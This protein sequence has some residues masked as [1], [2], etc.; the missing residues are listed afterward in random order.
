MSDFSINNKHYQ[1]ISAPHLSNGDD[2][3]DAYIKK[4]KKILRGKGTK[5]VPILVPSYPLAEYRDSFDAVFEMSSYWEGAIYFLHN[6]LGATSKSMQIAT[7]KRSL[8]NDCESDFEKLFFKI[9]NNQGQLCFL[10]AFLIREYYSNHEQCEN[11][12][13]WERD[14]SLIPSG[15]SED[16]EWLR[17]FI[18]NFRDEGSKYPNPFFG[19]QNPLHLGL[20]S[21]EK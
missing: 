9:W 17:T 11:T 1:Y 2:W 10:K 5:G 14:T 7:V 21:L 20:I 12:W 4:I 16:L 6:V 8:D 3:H 15:I 13:E 19:G 18:R